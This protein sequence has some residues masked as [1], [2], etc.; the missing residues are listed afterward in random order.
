LFEVNSESR[1]LAA[2]GRLLG[3]SLNTAQTLMLMLIVKVMQ[4]EAQIGAVWGHSRHCMA[5]IKK[6]PAQPSGFVLHISI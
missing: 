3:E 6:P 2:G 1:G 4:A 5:G